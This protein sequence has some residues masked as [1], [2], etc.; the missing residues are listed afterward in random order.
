MWL[1]AQELRR[2][3]IEDLMIRNSVKEMC[4][5]RL[6]SMGRNMRLCMSFVNVYQG[7]NLGRGR[8]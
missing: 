7:V 1:H 8:F 3:M 5:D 2:D 6:L 4:V